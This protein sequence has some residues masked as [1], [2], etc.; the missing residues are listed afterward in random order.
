VRE[1]KKI[2]LREDCSQQ[3]SLYGG[4]EAISAT[5]EEKGANIDNQK[6]RRAEKSLLVALCFFPY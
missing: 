1:S 4:S 3:V 5:R 6:Q 2:I